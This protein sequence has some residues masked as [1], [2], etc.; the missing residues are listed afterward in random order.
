MREERAAC[1]P[2][3]ARTDRS[4]RP[5][6]WVRVFVVL[7]ILVLGAGVALPL[8][9]GA[10]ALL[11][12]SDAGAPRVL[13]TALAD[14]AQSSP[15]APAAP[16]GSADWAPPVIRVGFG[17]VAGLAVA[18]VLRAC[19]RLALL[20]L[21]FFLLAMIGLEH[22]GLVEIRWAEVQ[23]RYE[24]VGLQVQEQLRSFWMYAAA[25]VP[26]AAS[27]TAGLAAGFCHRRPL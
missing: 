27:A 12:A 19:L 8:A 21:G 23:S 16:S 1:G 24:A 3:L 11:G 20:I 4:G 2:R 14:A 10:P 15:A 25:H 26:S 22:A 6:G 17:F 5:P 13:A 9:R 18:Y 7:S